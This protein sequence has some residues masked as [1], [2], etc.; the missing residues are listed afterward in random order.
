MDLWFKVNGFG[1]N[2]SGLRLMVQ[3]LGSRVM[4]YGSEFRV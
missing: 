1:F 2:F 3:D 4:V